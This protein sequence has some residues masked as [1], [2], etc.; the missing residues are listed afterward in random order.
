VLQGAVHGSV[1]FAPVVV[2]VAALLVGD[3]LQDELWPVGAGIQDD[4][5]AVP[6]SQLDLAVLDRPVDRSELLA[7][8]RILTLA[9]HGILLLRQS[10]SE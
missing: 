9:C 10:F 7:L 1:S 3:C 5:L 6:L 2:T 4:G 8:V